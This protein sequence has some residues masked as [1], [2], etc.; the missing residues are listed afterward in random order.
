MSSENSIVLAAVLLEKKELCFTPAGV[1]VFEA[2]FHHCGEQFE[3]E[4]MR[5]VEFDFTAM[6]FADTAMRLD[7]IQPGKE[8]L[9]RGFLAQRSLRS[10]KL[11]VHITEFKIRS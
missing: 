8:V 6:A 1:A 10:T 4:A 3:A 7:K 2:R 5:K 11:T 9:M